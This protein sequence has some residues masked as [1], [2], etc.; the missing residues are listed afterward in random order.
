M[1]SVTAVGSLNQDPDRPEPAPCG[2]PASAMTEAD[3]PKLSGLKPQDL[4]QMVAVSD[5]KIRDPH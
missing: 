3:L 1:A 4:H 5:A 2:K